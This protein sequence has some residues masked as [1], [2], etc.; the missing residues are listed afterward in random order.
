MKHCLI[1]P[2]D[3]IDKLNSAA[4]DV[5]TLAKWNSIGVTNPDEMVNHIVEELNQKNIKLSIDHTRT[6]PPSIIKDR[7]KNS[8]NVSKFA[9][10]FENEKGNI[11]ALFFYIE[12]NVGSANDF[13]SRYV[14]P[15]I[16]GIYKTTEDRA[17]DMHINN[18]PVYIVSLCSTSRITN[19]SV[20]KNIVL[21]ETMGFTYLDV[22]HNSYYDVINKS[23]IDGNPVTKI[24]TLEDLDAFLKDSDVNGYFDIDD[25]SKTIAIKSNIL[26]QS[27]NPSA[28]LYRYA[29]RV[30]PAA[31]LAS[32]KKFTVDSS[33]IATNSTEAIT[34]LGR[35]LS[36][37]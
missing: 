22:F 1:L 8:G 24:A 19:N 25:A 21:A 2:Q 13:L 4:S 37:F 23:D 11:D 35:Y 18:M 36:R 28:E 27:S 12:P 34:L 7:I 5:D 15:V 17:V 32:K 33:S 16:L 30:I 14:M 3:M 20:K 26:D 31:Y 6:E 9:G 29:L 10:Y